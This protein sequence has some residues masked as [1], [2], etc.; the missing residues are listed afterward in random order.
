M[1]YQTPITIQKTMNG[2]MT[3]T[4]NDFHAERR[5]GGSSSA[6]S[7]SSCTGRTSSDGH[8]W[9]PLSACE[10]SSGQLGEARLETEVGDAGV[11]EGH[12]EVADDA[13]RAVPDITITRVERNTAS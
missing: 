12:V 6:C 3:S 4:R 13:A 7:S 5:G 2:P 8:E 10:T 11:A 1:K 9:A